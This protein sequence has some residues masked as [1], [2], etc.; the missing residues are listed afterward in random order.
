MVKSEVFLEAC[1]KCKAACCKLGGPDFS[2]K[3]MKQTLKAGFPNHFVKISK[4]H[5]EL[6]CK[7]GVCPY[8]NKDYSCKIHK[9]KPLMCLCWPIG[10]DLEKNKKTLYLFKC[11]ITKLL[12]KEAI[13]EFKKEA[14]KL[15][16]EMLR[17]AWCEGK[18]KL[19]KA[20]L[21]RIMKRF[22]KFKK[23]RLR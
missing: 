12:S 21:K 6:R 23:K 5:Y 8:L 20:E 7:K 17:E 10:V 16:N 19:S 1:Q 3:E 2:K 4:N 14:A 18:T 22:H 11:P 9:V 15:P 13:K